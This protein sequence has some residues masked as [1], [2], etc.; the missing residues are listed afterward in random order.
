MGV[1]VVI[2]DEGGEFLAAL[3]KFVPHIIDPL[4]AKTVAVWFAAQ[5]VCDLDIQHMILKGDSLQ[6]ISNLKKVGPL[7]SG[8]GQLI[9]DTKLLLSSL[10][11]CGFQHVKRGA[12]KAAHC[13]AK[14]ALFLSIFLESTK[15]YLFNSYKPIYLY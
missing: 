11:H 10:V 6:V 4:I 9:Y 12:N 5:F 14:F 2:R 7:G 13:M 15:R 3:T 1:G 8:S